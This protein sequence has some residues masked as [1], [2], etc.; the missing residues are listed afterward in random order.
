MFKHLFMFACPGHPAARG[1][2]REG[3][4]RLPEAPR[5]KMVN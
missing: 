3:E 5:A 2:P 4:A 1:R